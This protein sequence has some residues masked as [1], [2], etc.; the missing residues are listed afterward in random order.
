[1]TSHRGNH[2]NYQTK[3]TR[4]HSK[5]CSLFTSPKR[6]K[7]RKGK[8]EEE[9]LEKFILLLVTV[10]VGFEVLYMEIANGFA[11]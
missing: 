10:I 5:A 8:R 9:K 7:E 2:L 11:V 4:S 1:M 3:Q 6:L